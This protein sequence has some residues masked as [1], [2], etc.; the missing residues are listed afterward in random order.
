[1]PSTTDILIGLTSIANE[2]RS[3][4]MLWHVALAGSLAALLA[5]W[6]PSIRV[7]G[8]LLASPF[9]SVMAAA[10][11]TGNAFN[12]AVFAA[13]AL[14]LVFVA[15]RLSRAPVRVGSPQVVIAGA[16]LVAFG[17]GYPHF[18]ETEGW[19][20]YLYAAP[21]GILPCP[22]LSAVIGMTLVFDHL[23]SRAW[24]FALATAGLVYGAIGAF[25]LGVTLDH[26]L[27]VGALVMAVAGMR[28]SMSPSIAHVTPPHT[29]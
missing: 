9:V 2:W 17:S 16:V 6:R 23:G 3:V 26:V 25:V 19:T 18:V 15:S 1:M 12:G 13:L 29:A 8:Y 21:L 22:T 5:G 4:A 20:P 24:A 28:S 10:I 7:V 14:V 27:L 11:A